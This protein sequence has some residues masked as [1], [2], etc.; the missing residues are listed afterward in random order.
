MSGSFGLFELNTVFYIVPLLLVFSY[1]ADMPSQPKIASRAS[2][3]VGLQS[4]LVE[5]GPS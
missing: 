3:S 4:I 1:V 5:V 2:D